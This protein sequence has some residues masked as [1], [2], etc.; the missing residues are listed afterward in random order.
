MSGPSQREW[1]NGYKFRTFKKYIFISH[2]APISMH[3]KKKAVYFI[4]SKSCLRL[5]LKVCTCMLSCFSRVQLY[6]T[7]WTVACQVPL[8]MGFSRQESWSGLPCPPPGDLPNPGIEPASLMSP[9]LQANS[10]PLATPGKHKRILKACSS[11]N[12]N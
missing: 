6:V 9:V 10:L 5:R 8:P 12:T 7:L 4:R 1:T 2:G 3:N 11:H